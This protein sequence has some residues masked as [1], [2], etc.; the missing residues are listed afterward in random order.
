MLP[1]L[2]ELQKI[3]YL[4]RITN[5]FGAPPHKP[6]HRAQH[7]AR[8][9]F[10]TLLERVKQGDRTVDF[11]ALRFAYTETAHYNP[12]SAERQM[13]YQAMYSALDKKEYDK[14]LEYNNQLLVTNYLDLDAH[15]G[16]YSARE[17]A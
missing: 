7:A 3:N 12:Y 4:S 6:Y 2:L 8:T 9:S 16:A 1:G 13:A 17:A 11:Q 5:T 10:E 15:F 14:A